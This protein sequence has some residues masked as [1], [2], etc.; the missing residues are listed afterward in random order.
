[1]P[2]ILLHHSGNSLLLAFSHMLLNYHPLG[3]KSDLS[4]LC[5]G[6]F[7]GSPLYSE[8]KS[9]SLVL[10]LDEHHGFLCW[11]QISFMSVCPHHPY[12]CHPG[13]WLCLKCA[14]TRTLCLSSTPGC[15]FPQVLSWLSPHFL[16]ISSNATL[17]QRTSLTILNKL[18]K[19]LGPH[20]HPLTFG[21]TPLTQCRTIHSY[22]FIVG[23]PH[24]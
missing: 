4:L 2:P 21:F 9:H 18:G 17:A 24:K 19:I 3:K 7:D 16:H 20:P 12:S 15:F 10:C 22:L 8:W 6:P 1:M 11:P 23:V 13:S 5:S 14:I